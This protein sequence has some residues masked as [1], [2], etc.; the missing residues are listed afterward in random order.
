MDLDK[1]ISDFANIS[2]DAALGKDLSKHQITISKSL[3]VIAKDLNLHAD[4]PKR[5][6]SR[7]LMEMGYWLYVFQDRIV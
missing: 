1:L 3:I 4:N 6:L 2:A 7:D 5:P